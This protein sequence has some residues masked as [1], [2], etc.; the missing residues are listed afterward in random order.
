MVLVI[1]LLT[2]CKIAQHVDN[3][4]M[5]IATNGE[6]HSSVLMKLEKQ[7][8]KEGY[9]LELIEAD[10]YETA[11]NMLET[12]EIDATYIQDRETILLY[13]ETYQTNLAEL[14]A[15]H[16][17]P[18]RI[19]SKKFNSLD[20]IELGTN[21]I[22]PQESSYAKR[23]LLLLQ[24]LGVI[25]YKEDI[26]EEVSLIN[27]L[28]NPKQLTFQKM[29][30]QYLGQAYEMGDLICMPSSQAV[31]QK[32]SFDNLLGTEEATPERVKRYTD[33]MVVKKELLG[34]NKLKTL[35]STM[36]D[37]D[38]ASYLKKNYEGWLVPIY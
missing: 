7:L 30:I 14:Q 28:E 29:D 5:I 17:D 11:N 36:K 33:I 4:K 22:I 18:I 27:I 21:I 2:G 24:E 12:G 26:G 15:T 38:I 19:F 32:L 23:A 3:Q 25:S 13:N 35:Q 9:E 31:N 34:T 6:L 8:L 10:T 1:P 16:Y 20:E 37:I